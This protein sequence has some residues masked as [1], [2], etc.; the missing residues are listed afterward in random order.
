[1]PR[2][3][4]RGELLREY[5]ERI[6]QAVKTLAEVS[7]DVRTPRSVRRAAQDA[8]GALQ[9]KGLTPAVRAANAIS[10]LDEVAQ[11]PDLSSFI[12]V[13]IWNAISMIEGIRD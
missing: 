8:I 6:R 10:I 1:M 9:T 13:R 4:V 7:Q 11:D 5:E 2:R 3:K 12:R